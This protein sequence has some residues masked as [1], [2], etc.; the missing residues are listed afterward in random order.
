MPC[1]WR[2]HDGAPLA[3][4]EFDGGHSRIKLRTAVTNLSVTRNPNQVDLGA[5]AGREGSM[6]IDCLDFA[7]WPLAAGACARALRGEASSEEL[8]L[9]VGPKLRAE[10]RFHVRLSRIE[11]WSRG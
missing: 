5:P 11:L 8:L 1:G 4:P 2:R 9:L 7:A 10:Q 3:L 6:E